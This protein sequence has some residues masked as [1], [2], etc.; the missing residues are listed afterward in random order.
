MKSVCLDL[1]IMLLFGTGLRSSQI[2]VIIVKCDKVKSIIAACGKIHGAYCRFDHWTVKSQVHLYEN[3]PRNCCFSRYFQNI[4]TTSVP[5]S[6]L[7]LLQDEVN[8]AHFDFDRCITGITM[9]AKQALNGIVR[10]KPQRT[11]KMWV[12]SIDLTCEYRY[13]CKST[14]LRSPYYSS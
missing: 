5:S 8:A 13:R 12:D 2:L 11:Q 3:F 14:I 6:L 9:T 7:F 10:R 1:K 4:H